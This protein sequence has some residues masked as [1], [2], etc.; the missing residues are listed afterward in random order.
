[1]SDE[2]K[3]ESAK[4]MREELFFT[5]FKRIGLG[6]IIGLIIGFICGCWFINSFSIADWGWTKYSNS[7]F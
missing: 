2:E 3:K 6:L 4:R 5:Q 1:M 7:K